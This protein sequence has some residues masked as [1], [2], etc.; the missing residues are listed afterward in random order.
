MWTN[1]IS[2][3]LLIVAR[4]LIVYLAVM[5]GIRLSGKRELGQMTALDFVLLLL[6]ANTVQNAMTGPD[7]SVNGGLIAA[8][9]LLIANLVVT[10]ILVKNRKVRKFVEGSP[11]VLIY[12]GIV[13]KKHLQSEKISFD[14]LH[15]AIREHGVATIQEVSIAVLEIDGSISV[16][17][18]DELPTVKLPHH[19]IKYIKRP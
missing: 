14:E 15:Q 17:K 9:T 6:V 4:T 12:H 10:R 7:T 11:T 19:R 3:I 18:N 16:L 13:I 8:A 2:V 5:I 1:D